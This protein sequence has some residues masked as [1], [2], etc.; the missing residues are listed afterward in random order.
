VSVCCAPGP[1]NDGPSGQ[2]SGAQFS[3]PKNTVLM[4]TPAMLSAL[5]KDP[6]GEP[7]SSVDVTG[8]PEGGKGSVTA[9]DGS[10]GGGGGG[11][12]QFVPRYKATGESVFQVTAKDAAGASSSLPIKVNVLG[13]Q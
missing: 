10:S 9:L 1:V 4:L 8:Q 13:E 3:T 5:F 7:L 11:G 6:D 12:L 2:G